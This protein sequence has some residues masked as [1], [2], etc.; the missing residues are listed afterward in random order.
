[1]S[2]V[3]ITV[4]VDTDK[5]RGQA[6]GEIQDR[7]IIVMTD[8]QPDSYYDNPTS[9]N[10]RDKLHTMCNKDDNFEWSIEALNGKDDV[11]FVNCLGDDLLNLFKTKPQKEEG[12]KKFKAQVKDSFSAQVCVWYSFDIL[13]DGIQYSWD[14]NGE[15]RWPPQ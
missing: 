6:P 8:N 1:M 7:T 12:T 2:K 15:V 13:L 14:P 5:L 11:T 4:T 3:E 9:A 10:Y